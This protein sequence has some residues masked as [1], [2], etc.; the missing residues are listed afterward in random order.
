MLLT[1]LLSL[2]PV[3]VLANPVEKRWTAEE[4]AGSTASDIFP[5][6]GSE[7]N[8]SPLPPLKYFFNW[9]GPRIL[10]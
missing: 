5:P 3:L 8:P 2:L 1:A 10:L 6:T 9:T 7:S 4:Y